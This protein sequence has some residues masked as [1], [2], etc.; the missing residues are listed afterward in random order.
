MII[1]IVGPAGDASSRVLIQFHDKNAEEI[2]PQKDVL[3]LFSVSS[4]ILD[5]FKTH[6]NQFFRSMIQFTIF[7]SLCFFEFYNN[8]IRFIVIIEA[9]FKYEQWGSSLNGTIGLTLLCYMNLN[10]VGFIINK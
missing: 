5:W 4:H 1:W 7:K 10:S 9:S 2:T 3:R 8:V 6:R